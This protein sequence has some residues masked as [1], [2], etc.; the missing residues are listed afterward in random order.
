VYQSAD[1]RA[2]A[3]KAG[4][5]FEYNCAR[6]LYDSGFDGGAFATYWV[7]D[8][9]DHG[10]FQVGARVSPCRFLY[11]TI[12]PDGLVSKDGIGYGASVY[13]PSEYFRYEFLDHVG[14]E[15][16]RL[17]PFDGSG[18]GNLIGISFASRF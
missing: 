10:K 1:Q 7:A 11:G 14:I 8:R 13:F 12:A 9:D 17:H 3:L 18:S 15:V 6:Y 2:D 4:L 5:K 16:G